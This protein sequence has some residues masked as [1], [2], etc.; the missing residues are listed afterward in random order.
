MATVAIVILSL[1]PIPDHAPLEDVPLIDKWVHFVFY[2]GLVFAA[3]IDKWQN[4][5]AGS[6]WHFAVIVCILASLLGGLMEFAQGCTTYRSCEMLDFYADSIGAVLAT[7]I[8]CVGRLLQD[9]V[10]HPS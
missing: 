5:S 2:A 4:R 3:W 7:L 9:A 1:A 8:I 10:R 6:W